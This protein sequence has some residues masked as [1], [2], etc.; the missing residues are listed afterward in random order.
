[1]EV[2]LKTIEAQVSGGSNPSLSAR[3]L[4]YKSIIAFG[5]MREWP[6]RAPC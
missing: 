1:M 6:N 5:E 4:D 2:V 3:V